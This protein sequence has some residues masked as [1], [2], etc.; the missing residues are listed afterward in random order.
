MNRKNGPEST[1][2][3]GDPQEAPG[4]LLEKSRGVKI[5]SL[6]IVPF[7]G[8][9]CAEVFGHTRTDVPHGAATNPPAHGMSQENRRFGPDRAL[10]SKIGGRGN[11][12]GDG[13][14]DNIC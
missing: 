7:S 11:S 4:A 9:E 5:W 2:C 10:P 12:G 6:C 13:Q 1:S 8:Q 3:T 14:Q